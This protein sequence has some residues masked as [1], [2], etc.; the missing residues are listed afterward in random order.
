MS[1]KY[2]LEPLITA[3]D[4]R[5]NRALREVQAKQ[6]ELAARR[7][8][9]DAAMRR[10]VEIRDQRAT[11]QQY[12]VNVTLS[13]ESQANG[14]A[15]VEPRILLLDAQI[16]QQADVVVQAEQ[17]VA[18][19]EEEVAKAL[20]VFRNA[21]AKLD[22]LVE[23]KQ[24]WHRELERAGRRAENSAAQELMQYRR[25]ATGESRYAQ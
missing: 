24:R 13:G 3:R 11:Q 19:A 17:R 7:T 20:A 25:T 23:Q 4:V 8:E 10:L 12:L 15:R 5:R 1:R 16:E 6:A 9:R 21:Q 18:A 22:A 2:R 14:Y